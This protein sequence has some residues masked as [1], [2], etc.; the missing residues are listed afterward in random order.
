MHSTH[1]LLALCMLACASNATAPDDPG[2]L[3]PTRLSPESEPAA[4][5]DAGCSTHQ[6]CIERNAGAPYRCRA[7]DATCVSLLNADCARILGGADDI[8]SDDAIRI[9]LLVVD[10]LD[11][12]EAEAAVELAR[13]EIA[14]ALTGSV[15]TAPS[16]RVRPV[17]VVECNTDGSEPLAAVRHL[18]DDVEVSA[19]LGGFDAGHVLAVARQETIP[20]G[21]LQ[22]TPSAT[23]DAISALDDQDLVYRA[24]LP[25]AVLFQVLTPFID[26]FLRPALH[27]GE[28]ARA[29]EPLRTMLVYDPDPSGVSDADAITKSLSIDGELVPRDGSAFYRELRLDPLNL[30]DPQPLSVVAARAIINF[31]PQVIL[32]QTRDEEVLRAVERGWPSNV[33]KPYFVVSA[34]FG[35]HLPALVGADA[36]LRRRSFSLLGVSEGYEP[37]RFDAWEARL[38]ASAPTLTRPV[39]HVYGPNLYDSM[40]ML[41]YALSTLGDREPTGL[42]LVPGFRRLSGPGTAIPFGPDAITAALDELT[43][44][45]AIDYIGIN[46]A[47]HYTAAGDRSG[48]AAIGCVTIDPAGNA[49]GLKPS[50]FAYDPAS[51]SVVSADVSCP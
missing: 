22:I 9:G 34:A 36:D 39:S 26:Q 32:Y 12:A 23:D 48:L 21:V 33:P 37:A 41:A 6:Q 5:H 7:S 42:S 28:R 10:D 38:R 44:G 19:L 40:Y 51:Q 30:L 14:S 43:A 35:A 46:G 29:E 49:I 20:G 50:G 18:I 4:S 47:F 1:H 13:A 3:V 25:G 45:N 2:T 31:E 24:Q 27:A 15:R 16:A 11:G 8:A 17:V